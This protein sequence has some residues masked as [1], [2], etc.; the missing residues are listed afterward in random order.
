[1]IENWIDLFGFEFTRELC[2]TLNKKADLCIRVNTLKI[3][4]ENLEKQL[5]RDGIK[6]K[7]GLFMKE[8][9]YILEHN[10]FTALESFKNGFFLPQDES[11]MLASKVLDAKT[12]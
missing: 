10:K 5:I 8:A 11:S 6:I 12:W 3:S 7:S 2:K 4:V 1:M 9:F